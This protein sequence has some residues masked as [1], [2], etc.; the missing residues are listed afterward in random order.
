MDPL[1][2]VMLDGL[3]KFTYANSLSSRD[4]KEQLQLNEACPKDSF[5]FP[6]IDQIVDAT[7]G[8]GILLFLDA[9]SRYH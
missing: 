2:K 3:E 9:F 1:E 5:P 7:S 6:C 8:H 4:K